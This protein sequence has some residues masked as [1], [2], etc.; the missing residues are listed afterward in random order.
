MN[1]LLVNAGQPQHYNVQKDVQHEQPQV[2]FQFELSST[3]NTYQKMD[4]LAGCKDKN[5]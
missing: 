2:G 3:R 4:P 5:T 1:N